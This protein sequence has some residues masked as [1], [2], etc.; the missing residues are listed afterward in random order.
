MS[1][2]IT[3]ETEHARDMALAKEIAETLHE[4]YPG[5]LWG[6]YVASGVA[7]I[8]NFYLSSRWGMVLH[9]AKIMGDAAYRRRRVIE[10]GGE[11]LERAGAPRGARP[12]GWELAQALEVA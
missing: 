2:V 8:K 3:A 9:Y 7:V 5:W 6:V 10:S 1:D 12:E 4:H 11:L